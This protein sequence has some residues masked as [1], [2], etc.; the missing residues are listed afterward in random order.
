MQLNITIFMEVMM[1]LSNYFKELI[2]VQ[3]TIKQLKELE[4]TLK[5]AITELSEEA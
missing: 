4:E 2:A 3:D 1:M 5:N